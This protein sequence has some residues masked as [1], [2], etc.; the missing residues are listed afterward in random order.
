MGNFL[1]RDCF[2]RELFC[3]HSFGF[4]GLACAATAFILGK[5][6]SDRVPEVAL[7]DLTPSGRP[8]MQLV[9]VGLCSL[10]GTESTE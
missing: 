1:R 7:L 5:A 6:R 4:S 3:L 2:Q 10:L 9:L 8:V